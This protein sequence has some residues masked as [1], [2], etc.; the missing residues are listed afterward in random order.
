SERFEI[1]R[2]GGS[3]AATMVVCGVFQFDHPAARH[4]FALLPK[5]ITIESWNSPHT[6][7]IQSKLRAMAAEAREMHP[8]G[9]TVITRLADILVI[10][11]IRSWMKQDPAAKTGWLG[12]LHDETD[13]TGN[14]A[15][16]S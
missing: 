3:G 4:L 10:Q 16:P 12:A 2:L 14:L 8:R 13:R 1:L 15:N 6:E 11:A 7:W 9:E 5:V